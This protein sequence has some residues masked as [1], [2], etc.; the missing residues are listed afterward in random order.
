MNLF[1]SLG[2][3]HDGESGAEDC[4]P[5]YNNIMTPVAGRFENSMIL[6]FSTCSINAFKKIL[7]S[8]KYLKSEFF[9]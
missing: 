7:L 1:L 4:Q 9:N 5:S 8:N 6:T 2:A 3:V